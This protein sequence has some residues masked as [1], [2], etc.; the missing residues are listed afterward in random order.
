MKAF[1]GL[2]ENP[3]A[4]PP[5]P[6]FLYWSPTH[7]ETFQLFVR[8]QQSPKGIMVVTGA[9]GTGK[10][11]LLKAFAAIQEPR[12]RIVSLPH[13]ASSVDDLFVLLAQQMGLESDTQPTSDQR[14]QIN[15][16][17]LTRVQHRE[18]IVLL[19]DNAH[20]W[21][22]SLL[23]E[24]EV[25]ARL[26]TSTHPLFHIILA[27]PPTLPDY[28]T[29][30]KLASLRA[31]IEGIGEL[32]PFDL[33]DTQAYIHQRLT[34]AGWHKGWLFDPAAVEVIYRYAQGIPRAI[35]QLCSQALLAGFAAQVPRIDAEL[36][37][38]V[39]AR[40][41]LH[42]PAPARP[43][44]AAPAYRTRDKRTQSGDLTTSSALWPSTVGQ[45]R[46][47]TA[48][49]RP[50]RRA[51]ALLPLGVIVL[52]AVGSVV[53]LG[54]WLQG[55][56]TPLLALAPPVVDR[57]LAATPEPQLVS[58]RAREAE[59]DTAASAVQLDPA[60]PVAPEATDRREH[61]SSKPE[62]QAEPSPHETPPSTAGA[63]RLMATALLSKPLSQG[64]A[65]A[66]PRETL[67]QPPQPPGT[68]RLA[69][70]PKAQP[71]KPSQPLARRGPTAPPAMPKLSDPVAHDTPGA[72]ERPAPSPQRQAQ[73]L[74]D[75]PPLGAAP[76][77]QGATETRFSG[78]ASDVP[79][80]TQPRTPL[81]PPTEV[82]E[83]STALPRS[84]EPLPRE[85]ARP[86]QRVPTVT[87]E[88]ARP[89]PARPLQGR[90]VEIHTG[91]AR[92]SVLI[93]G[94]YMGHTSVVI[95][96]PLGV[97]TMAIDNPGYAQMMWKMHVDPNGVALHMARSR[98]WAWPPYY[99]PRVLAH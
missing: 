30:P 24:I 58:G 38:H 48:R 63:K 4:L 1:Y 70:T 20:E 52:I 47:R 39:A 88:T 94:Q 8:S 98:G 29:A 71:H 91:L 95:H 36:I 18:K 75:D 44:P 96:L 50:V 72:A 13:A 42:E 93:N 2:T 99:M 97:Y 89:V 15:A 74:Q 81:W 22:E 77:P 21:S 67:Q 37:R 86:A 6:K 56:R 68:T 9:R 32:S 90:T 12:T 28:L 46:G 85:A 92:A 51:R 19:L 40:M 11:T 87:W 61:R 78:E 35:N 27:G 7:R 33:L 26:G 69:R 80:A 16:W 79:E 34:V 60:V 43:E 62:K 31:R 55:R 17:L 49:R 64:A 66:T 57:R 82:S 59:A 25:L 41:G 84:P 65:S 5:D 83:G 54:G 73:L 14:S 23:A 45:P 3:F 76:S 10:T 53:G